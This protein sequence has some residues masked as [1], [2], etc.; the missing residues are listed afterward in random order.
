MTEARKKRSEESA[1]KGMGGGPKE[2][3]L[4]LTENYAHYLVALLQGRRWWEKENEM[5]RTRTTTDSRCPGWEL[6]CSN[7]RRDG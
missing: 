7:G 2:M 5:D 4:K 3:K 1:I 6:V